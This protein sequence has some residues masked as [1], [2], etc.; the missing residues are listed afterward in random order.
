MDL[1]VIVAACFLLVCLLVLSDIGSYSVAK[2]VVE[3][4]M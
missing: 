1:D 2:A 4:N 3:L